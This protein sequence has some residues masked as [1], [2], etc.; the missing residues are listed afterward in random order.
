MVGLFFFLG[1][2]VTLVCPESPGGLG[3][4]GAE[5]GFWWMW[6]CQAGLGLH[7]SRAGGS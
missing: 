2:G 7:P 3:F 5:G 6:G 1:G 4:G